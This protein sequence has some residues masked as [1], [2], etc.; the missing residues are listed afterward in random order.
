MLVTVLGGSAALSQVSQPQAIEAAAGD[1]MP[2]EAFLLFLADGFEVDGNWQDPMT[3]ARLT[4]L[5][6]DIPEDELSWI[7]DQQGSQ[8]DFREQEQGLPAPRSATSTD[9]SNGEDYEQ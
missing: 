8:K 7:A 3:L 5:D 9:R 4:E 6:K 1:A 2:D